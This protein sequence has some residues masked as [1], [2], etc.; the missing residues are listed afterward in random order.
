MTAKHTPGPWHI[1]PK[2]H[3]HCRIYATG[4]GHAIA[5]TYDT[6]MNGIGVC[7]LTGPMNEANARLIAAAPELLDALTQIVECEKR[8]AADLRHREAW[9][10]VK[11]SEGRIAQAEAAIAKATGPSQ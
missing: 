3:G 9:K 11:F 1:G 5:R 8:R 2:P 7:A 10:L 6:E 4:E